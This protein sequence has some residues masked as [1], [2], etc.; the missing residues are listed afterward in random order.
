MKN[1]GRVGVASC[2]RQ[3]STFHFKV[4]TTLL[5]LVKFESNF[6]S[7][8]DLKIYMFE[9]K[10]VKLTKEMTRW[11]KGNF[12]FMPLLNLFQSKGPVDTIDV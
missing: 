1:G 10:S 4:A 8:L 12:S 9:V 3:G 7:K 6:Q 2:Y 5:N 11:S